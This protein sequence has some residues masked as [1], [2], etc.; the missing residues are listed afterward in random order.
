MPKSE[1]KEYITS[2]A[3]RSIEKKI[4]QSIETELA[5]AQTLDSLN[6]NFKSGISNMLKAL[7]ETMSKELKGNMKITSN[8]IE[9]VKI[10]S[11]YF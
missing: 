11:N 6:K 10:V 9:N 5:E 7:N 8:Q 4:K 2:D 3:D 1:P